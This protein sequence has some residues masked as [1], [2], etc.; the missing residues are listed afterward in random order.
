[1][2]SVETRKRLI[3]AACEVILTE[4]SFEAVTQ[5]EV[6]KRANVPASVIGYHF[7]SFEGLCVAALQRAYLRL[8]SGRLND[9]QST[10]DKYRPAPAPLAEVIRALVSR[11]VRMWLDPRSE[12][13]IFVYAQR[14]QA[15]SSRPELYLSLH[16]DIEHHRI[17]VAALSRA[18]PWLSDAQISLR[19]VAAL[20]FRSEMIRHAI[21]SATLTGGSI[22]FDDADEVIEAMVGVIAA[23]FNPP[24]PEGVALP[25]K[26]PRIRRATK[27]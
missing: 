8:N 6:A 23:M 9:L 13:Q 26:L 4:R 10:V 16:E 21:R 22:D 15:M 20:G 19:L 3:N 1:M 2:S 5:R 27:H 12:H 7:G 24:P 18:A 14:M 11:S 25:A 17:F